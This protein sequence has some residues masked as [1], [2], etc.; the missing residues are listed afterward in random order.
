M[1][2]LTILSFHVVFPV[3][4][5]FTVLS[6]I[7]LLLLILVLVL[8]IYVSYY[9]GNKKTLFFFP[10]HK[11]IISN[12]RMF[13]KTLFIAWIVFWEAWEPSRGKSCV[14]LTLP[15]PY[16]MTG[17]WWE[18]TPHLFVSQGWPT[19]MEFNARILYYPESLL[20]GPM[21]SPLTP[22]GES[23]SD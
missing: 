11:I 5:L 18:P 17:I 21:I 19:Y 4:I 23:C 20:Y 9:R 13:R 2:Y 3:F 1:I 16:H 8:I 10:F 12:S 14:V 7:A 22:S 15:P 6:I